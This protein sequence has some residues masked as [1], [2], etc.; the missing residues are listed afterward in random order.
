MTAK[1]LFALSSLAV[2]AMAQVTTLKVYANGS[3][4]PVASVPV[5]TVDS[6]KFETSA[7]NE[8]NDANSVAVPNGSWGEIGVQGVSD[9]KCYKLSSITGVSNLK[10][11]NNGGPVVNTTTVEV[12]GTNYVKQTFMG[13]YTLQ[14]IIMDLTK[15]YP[16]SG[17]ASNLFIKVTG[18]SQTQQITWASW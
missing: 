3:T 5:S 14:T 13:P 9:F 11:Q 2:A 4:T 18:S 17:F 6:V 10:I 1:I 7:A 8:C 15:G 12:T 16:T